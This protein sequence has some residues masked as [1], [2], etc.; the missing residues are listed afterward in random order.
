MAAAPPP[1]LLMPDELPVEAAYRLLVKSTEEGNVRNFLNR[2]DT[3]QDELSGTI[4]PDSVLN[5]NQEPL[6]TKLDA[7]AHAMRRI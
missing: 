7:I 6:F 3:F 4:D 1:L 2:L 5:T